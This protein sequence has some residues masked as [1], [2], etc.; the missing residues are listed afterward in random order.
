MIFLLYSE[1]KCNTVYG[2]QFDIDTF[3]IFHEIF[4]SFL[5]APTNVSQIEHSGG[6]STAGQGKC[7]T[8]EL[9]SD[10]PRF[11]HLLQK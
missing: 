2:R 7:G 5:S 1:I 9:L 3:N 10:R 6:Q 8:C 11:L 4:F